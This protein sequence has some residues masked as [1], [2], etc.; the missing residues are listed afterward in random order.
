MEENLSKNSFPFRIIFP[1]LLF[2]FYVCPVV[3]QQVKYSDRCTV[4]VV[5]LTGIR[6][7]D[8]DNESAPKPKTK[9]LGSFD[10]VIGEE[11]L[12]TR[13]FRLPQTK[14]YVVA[15]VWYTDES[16]AG[17]DSQDSVSLQ[18][19]ISTAPKRDV[20]ASLQFAEAEVLVKNFDVARVSTTYKTPRRSFYIIMECRKNTRP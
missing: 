2:V 10:T 16:M 5:D 9:E 20:L 13:S 14:L 17:E 3:A 4:G 11:E 12:T 18:L 1:L 19:T 15:S 6:S 8:R 7:V